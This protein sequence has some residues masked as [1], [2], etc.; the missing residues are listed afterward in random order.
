[1]YFIHF[2]LDVNVSESS[3]PLESTV[4][5]THAMSDAE[6]TTAILI[7]DLQRSE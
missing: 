4:L 3:F 2:A 1:M 5:I 6:A 7:E